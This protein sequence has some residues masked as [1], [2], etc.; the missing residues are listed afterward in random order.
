MS[1]MEALLVPPSNTLKLER[2]RSGCCDTAG[3]I[4]I[5]S[6]GKRG[7]MTTHDH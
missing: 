3:K 5:V 7:F 1:V 6:M 2:F 4:C